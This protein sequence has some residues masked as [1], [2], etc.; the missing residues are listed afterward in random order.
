MLKMN[1]QL[2]TIRKAQ[3]VSPRIVRKTGRGQETALTYLDEE[4]GDGQFVRPAAGNHFDY[5]DQRNPYRA[6]LHPGNNAGRG[7]DDTGLP[8]W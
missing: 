1:L 2:F 8:T 3:L 7:G 6:T 5:F 4:P